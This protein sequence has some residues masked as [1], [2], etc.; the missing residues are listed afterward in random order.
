MNAS[1]QMS[2]FVSEITMGKY[3]VQLIC[4]MSKNAIAL[5]LEICEDAILYFFGDFHRYS[6]LCHFVPTTPVACRYQ[7]EKY[8]V[9][10]Y[11]YMTSSTKE[12]VGIYNRRT[13]SGKLIK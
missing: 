12:L 13:K 3:F 2:L 9:I 1:K 7:W 11:Y 8:I 10:R 6:R 5:S 4:K